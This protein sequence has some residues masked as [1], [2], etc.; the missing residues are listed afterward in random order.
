MSSMLHF[1]LQAEATYSP[2]SSIHCYLLTVALSLANF[3]QPCDPV[4]L[5]MIY[6]SRNVVPVE[7][8]MLEWM[9]S[10]H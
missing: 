6:G 2:W 9:N 5:V 4:M 8:S 1:L 7:Y 10:R 3:A